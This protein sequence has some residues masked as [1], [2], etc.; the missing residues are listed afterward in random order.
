[1]KILGILYPLVTFTVIL[2]TANHFVTDA[3]AGA[4]TL[5]LGFLIQ[6]LLTGRPVYLA[7]STEHTRRWRDRRPQPAG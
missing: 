5:A 3:I 1:M 4:A 2:A 6:R 7:P